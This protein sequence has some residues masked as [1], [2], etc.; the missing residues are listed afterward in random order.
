MIK[1]AID[2]VLELAIPNTIVGQDGKTYVD[3]PMNELEVRE[4]LAPVLKVH[5]LSAIIDYLRAGIDRRMLPDSR[6]IIHV[7][8][9]NHVDLRMELNKDKGR[10]LL[11]TSTAQECKFPF[12]RFLDLETFII[13]LQSHFVPTEN[14]AKLLALCG[15]LKTEQG[16]QQADDGVT[17]RVTAKTGIALVARVDVPNPIKLQPFRTFSEIEQPE[18]SFVFRLKQQ[19]DGVVAALFCADGDAWMTQAIHDIAGY[20][21]KRKNEPE[22]NPAKNAIILA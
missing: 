13:N 8:D 14:V 6:F 12:G 22:M 7:A 4:P 18:S 2:R 3:K 16:V 5:T 15:N 1:E 9:Y 21:T 17:Q 19:G 10:E 20:F 11:I